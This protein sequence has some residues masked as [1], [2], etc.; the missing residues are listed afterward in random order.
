[1]FYSFIQATFTA[2]FHSLNFVGQYTDTAGQTW[3]DY[4]YGTKAPGLRYKL[5]I[6]L[7]AV[8]CCML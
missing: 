6:H 3:H 8:P 1:M 5:Q 7:E 4:F 2:S